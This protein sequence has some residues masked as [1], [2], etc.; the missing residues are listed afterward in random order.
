[1]CVCVCVCVCEEID[2]LID[3]DNCANLKDSKKNRCFLEHSDYTSR[4]SILIFAFFVISLP[5]LN[6]FLNLKVLLSRINDRFLLA[7]GTLGDC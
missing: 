4:N 6:F 2:K 3:N 5:H 7:F 1:M